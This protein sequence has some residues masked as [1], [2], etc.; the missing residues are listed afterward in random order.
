MWS[1]FAALLIEPGRVP[2]GWSPFPSDEVSSPQSLQPCS[3]PCGCESGLHKAGQAAESSRQPSAQSL[4]RCK[5]ALA[6]LIVWTAVSKSSCLLHVGG[7]WQ[8]AQLEAARTEVYS[9]QQSRRACLAAFAEASR[10][11]PGPHLH[12][13]PHAAVRCSPKLGSMCQWIRRRLSWSQTGQS[14]EARS[15][16]RA[17]RAAGDPDTAESAM[18]VPRIHSVCMHRPCMQFYAILACSG[19]GIMILAFEKS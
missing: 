15:R 10:L 13:K 5:T 2:P 16:A 9:L 19:G 11:R 18:C 3:A 4:V 7:H 1:Y 8:Q 17:W 14:L 12:E 6:Q